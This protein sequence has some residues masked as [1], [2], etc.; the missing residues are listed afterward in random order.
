MNDLN[1]SYHELYIKAGTFKKIYF[2]NTCHENILKLDVLLEE[3]DINIKINHFNSIVIEK[4]KGKNINK[5][6]FDTVEQLNQ[7]D[8]SKLSGEKCYWKEDRSTSKKL[9]LKLQYEGLYC[10]EFDNSYSWVIP[11]NVK[12]RLEIYQPFK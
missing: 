4:A 12:Y 1:L 6:I 11:K 7:Y 9:E 5:L 3:N 8:A 2:S 10:I